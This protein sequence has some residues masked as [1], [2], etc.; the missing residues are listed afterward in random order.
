MM[1]RLGRGTSVGQYRSSDREAAES[2]L[3]AVGLFELHRK[4]YGELSGGQLR[5]LFIA[6]ALACEP[7][8]LLLDEPTANLDP[9]V[10][11][12]LHDLLRELSSHLTVVMVS[13]DPAFVSEF[14]QQVV[15]VNRKVHVHPTG[16]LDGAMLSEL[17]G[18]ETLRIVRHDQHF[19]NGKSY[20]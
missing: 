6:R 12:E 10:Q 1:G 5:R 16:E 20:D 13:H 3:R 8:M 7:D 2:A 14:V 17:Y 19:G 9:L 15:C 4:P 11:R 18:E